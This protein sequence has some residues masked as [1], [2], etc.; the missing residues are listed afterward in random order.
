M[1]GAATAGGRQQAPGG[2]WPGGPTSRLRPQDVAADRNITSACDTIRVILAERPGFL[3]YD[4]PYPLRADREDVG[5]LASGKHVSGAARTR[6]FILR[7]VL[8]TVISSAVL[9]AALLAGLTAAHR[10]VYYR[11]QAYDRHYDHLYGQLPA[12]RPDAFGQDA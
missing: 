12:C 1:T 8:R 9:T 5:A 10:Y 4:L 11:D 2:C 7:T 6:R 3:R